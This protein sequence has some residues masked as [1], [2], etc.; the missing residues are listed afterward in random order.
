MGDAQTPLSL[1]C[2]QAQSS[3]VCLQFVG[4]D[5]KVEPQAEDTNSGGREGTH[6]TF[7]LQVSAQPSL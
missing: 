7:L 6:G 1:L 5:G 4:H 3:A 2:A